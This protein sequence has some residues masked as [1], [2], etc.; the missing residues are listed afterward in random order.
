MKNLRLIPDVHKQQAI[1]KLGFA[2]DKALLDLVKKQTQPEGVK[3][4]IAGIQKRVTPHMLRHSFATHLLDN[5][6]DIRFI[7]ELL[8]HNSTKTTQRYTHVSQ[9]NLKRIES[10]I[11]RI[12]KNKNPDNQNIKNK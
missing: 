9:R 1:V 11:D 6:T 2:Y 3:A 5:G 8:G 7:Q 10:P 4:K 12:L